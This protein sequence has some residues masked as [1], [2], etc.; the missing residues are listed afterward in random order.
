MLMSGLKLKFEEGELSVGNSEVLEKML[1]SDKFNKG[2]M[3]FRPNPEDPTGFWREYGLIQTNT[4]QVVDPS[5]P[6][7]ADKDADARWKLISAKLKTMKKP[8]DLP[9]IR[10]VKFV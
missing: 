6:I 2:Y 9:N 3:G 10:A 1:R 7:L 8:E 4:I 5:Q